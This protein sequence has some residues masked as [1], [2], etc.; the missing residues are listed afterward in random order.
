MLI[1]LHEPSIVGRYIYAGPAFQ[2]V[3]DYDPQ[4]LI[5]QPGEALVH[6]DDVELVHEQWAH[7]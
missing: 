1:S 4:L 6:P 5:G 7:L 3:L 2:N